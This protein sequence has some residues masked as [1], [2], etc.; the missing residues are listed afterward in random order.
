[1]ESTIIKLLAHIYLSAIAGK[2]AKAQLALLV[3]GCKILFCNGL[4]GPPFRNFFKIK[5]LGF[6]VE[7]K[8][9]FQ[10]LHADLAL[11]NSNCFF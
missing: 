8:G 2:T 6:D 1:M 10:L 9:N 5:V 7:K 4:R 11:F 3:G